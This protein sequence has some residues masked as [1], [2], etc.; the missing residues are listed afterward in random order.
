IPV[1]KRDWTTA[2]DHGRLEPASM[3]GDLLRVARQGLGRSNGR[4]PTPSRLAN[5]I[6]PLASCDEDRLMICACGADDV[7]LLR[8]GFKKG[9]FQ[10]IDDTFGKN[11]RKFP[12]QILNT[13]LK[14]PVL[15][16]ALKGSST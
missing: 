3:R 12:L 9:R 8:P 16:L 4:V 5:D 13:L 15:F 7:A 2:A 14:L 10:M 11:L 6:T 1:R